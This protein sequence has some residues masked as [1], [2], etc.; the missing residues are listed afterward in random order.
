MCQQRVECV[1]KAMR[2]LAILY[3][4][5]GKLAQKQ[6]ISMLEAQQGGADDSSDDSYVGS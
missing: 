1:Q 3:R 2:Q 4:N 6:F 5:A